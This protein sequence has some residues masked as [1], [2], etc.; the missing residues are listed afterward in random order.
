VY[1]SAWLLF[2]GRLHNQ[3]RMEAVFC[4][5]AICDTDAVLAAEAPKQGAKGS[6]EWKAGLLEAVRRDP[7]DPRRW[8]DLGDALGSEG[9]AE[10]ARYCYARA[11]ALGPKIPALLARAASFEF[12]LKDNRKALQLMARV[13]ALDSGYQDAALTDYEQRK[14]STE[15]TLRYGIPQDAKTLSDYLRRM[16][17]QNRLS[18]AAETWA[19]ITSRGYADDK[20]AN[21]YVEMLASNQKFGDAEDVWARYAYTRDTSYPETNRV[22]N[23]SFESDPTGSRFDWTIEAVQ[24]AAADFDAAVHY[25]GARSLRIRFDGTQNV[26]DIG[27]RE[28]VFLKPG[29]YRFQAYV[30][31]QDVTTDE[32]VA[33]KVINSEPP[34]RINFTTQN[35]VGTNDWKLVEE[36]FQVVPGAGLLQVGL[37][38]KPSLRF[39]N[40]IRGTVW[41]DAVAITP[42]R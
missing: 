39:D 34:Y 13:L 41:I 33:F 30:R 3:P 2:E 8:C 27:I 4:R 17:Y 12:A 29:W 7:A 37:V 25:S 15:Q 36:T 35:A 16:I 42:S 5:F 26:G 32:G 20:L 18:D 14:I 9:D 10:K 19:W 22:F 11:L 38:R 23:G 24:G 21:E 1:A 6:A 31:T 40:L 28:T